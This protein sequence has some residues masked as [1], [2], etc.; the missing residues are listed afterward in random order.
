MP[1]WL[2]CDHDALVSATIQILLPLFPVS[3][4]G[5][6]CQETIPAGSCASSSQEDNPQTRADRGAEAGDQGGLWAVRHGWIRIH[7]CQGA[8][9]KTIQTL[10]TTSVWEGVYFHLC[11]TLT[12]LSNCARL[13]WE[14]WGLNRRRKRSRRWLVKWIRTAQEKSPSLISS[15]SW[16]RKW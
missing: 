6:E 12:P 4:L 5:D 13:R 1:V 14:L 7:R 8:Q 2:L 10:I 16:H 9:G 3:L 11:F 15:L